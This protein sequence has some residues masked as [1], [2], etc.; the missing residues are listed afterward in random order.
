M[1]F[2]ARLITSVS[3]RAADVY[4]KRDLPRAGV[5]EERTSGAGKGGSTWRTRYVSAIFPSAREYS[6][7]RRRW[8]RGRLREFRRVGAA[9][10]P[11]GPWIPP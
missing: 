9:V 3:G 1:Q 10:S 4:W 7:R 5:G 8:P 6:P 11:F 2:V